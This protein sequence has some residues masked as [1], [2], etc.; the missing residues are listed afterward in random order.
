[1]NFIVMMSSDHLLPFSQNFLVDSSFKPNIGLNL[2]T[3]DICILTWG[4]WLTQTPGGV[5]KKFYE[6]FLIRG[7]P[8]DHSVTI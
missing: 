3:L 8:F 4:P 7:F 1:M 2:L 5:L 6:D